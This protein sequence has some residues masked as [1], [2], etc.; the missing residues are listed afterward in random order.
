M[1][2]GRPTTAT[3]TATGEPDPTSKA[4]DD[5][6]QDEA[7]PDPPTGRWP[8]HDPAP[9]RLTSPRST[10]PARTHD[11][12][13]PPH[14]PPAPDLAPH[15]D[16]SGTAPPTRPRPPSDAP[17]VTGHAPPPAPQPRPLPHAASPTASTLTTYDSTD[18]SSTPTTRLSGATRTPFGWE[19]AGATCRKAGPSS[20]PSTPDQG[21]HNPPLPRRKKRA[22][23]GVGHRGDHR[24]V[25]AHQQPV[26]RPA[27]T[28]Y[29]ISPGSQ[30]GVSVHGATRVRHRRS[31][32][33]PVTPPS[34]TNSS[35]RHLAATCAEHLEA[36]AGNRSPNPTPPRAPPEGATRQHRSW[37]QRVWVNPTSRG[38]SGVA[39]IPP[40]GE[41]A[42]PHRER[43]RPTPRP[44]PLATGPPPTYN[45]ACSAW[46][47]ESGEAVR[48]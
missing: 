24:V 32:G 45:E 29:P 18:P 27:I 38:T 36:P 17:P 20:T 14:P 35:K 22:A 4:K 1:R 33:V 2:G 11:T 39:V 34:T 12:A 13:H 21:T 25:L 10:P 48:A 26:S 19:P 46:R 15:R 43:A 6:H 30:R 31:T 23:D 8:R 7:D 40:S 9:S 47:F 3:R 16:P 37:S 42:N 5:D 28:R 44:E 41:L